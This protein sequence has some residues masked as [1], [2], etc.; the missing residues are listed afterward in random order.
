MNYELSVHHLFIHIVLISL[1]C[2]RYDHMERLT[3]Q[4]AMAHPYF[5]PVRGT[6][7]TSFYVPIILQFLI[8]FLFC[9]DMKLDE[10]ARKEAESVAAGASDAAAAAKRG[11]GRT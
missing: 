7:V 10:E 11:S 8:T 5:R 2:D 4:E 3:A 9:I 6:I 1:P